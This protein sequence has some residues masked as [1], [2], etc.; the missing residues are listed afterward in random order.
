MLA[1]LE[2]WR[3]YLADGEGFLRSAMN[4]AKRRPEVF[5]PAVVFNLTAMAIEKY[6]MAFLMRRNELPY[7]HTMTDIIEM[8]ESVGG[9]A[10]ELAARIRW[11]DTF[12]EIC[13]VDAYQRRDP[14]P[15]EIQ[16]ILAIGVEVAEF[17]KKQ[18]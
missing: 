15:E 5:T 9:P 4:G 3:N 12:Q 1:T 16:E 6:L 13:D 14:T 18:I 11:L 10:P 8:V 2:D 7:N 17:V